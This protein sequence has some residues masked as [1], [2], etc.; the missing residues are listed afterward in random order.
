MYSDL[1]WQY[2]KVRKLFKGGNYSRAETIRGNTVYKKV[3][4]V[5]KYGWLI[6][7]H[8]PDY[9]LS[10]GTENSYENLGHLYFCIWGIIELVFALLFEWWFY[11]Y[12]NFI[13]VNQSISYFT[14]LCVYLYTYICIQIHWSLR[15]YLCIYFLIITYFDDYRKK[16]KRKENRYFACI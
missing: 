2:I 15:N 7:I 14:N 16:R 4:S 9:L 11:S 6:R 12:F 5:F 3:H 10:K 13:S 8:F 1:W